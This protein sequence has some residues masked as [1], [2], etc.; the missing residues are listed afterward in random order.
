MVEDQSG[1]LQ[2]QGA[3]SPRARCGG[4]ESVTSLEIWPPEA[5]G[6]FF[7]PAPSLMPDFFKG[8]GMIT[9]T[10]NIPAYVLKDLVRKLNPKRFPGIS[11]T[12]AALTG[13]VLGAAFFTPYIRAVVITDGG[14]V[15]A[16][17]DGTTDESRVLG[18]YSSILRHW[19]C[20]ISRAGLTPHEFMEVH[21][22]FAERVGFLGTT[23]A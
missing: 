2:T 23:N 16:R 20:L 19:T 22:L 7:L 6:L 13:F 1:N 18:S 12:L 10:Q 8:A 15:L 14:I 3:L 21:E 11:P 4:L 9:A 17:V 5:G